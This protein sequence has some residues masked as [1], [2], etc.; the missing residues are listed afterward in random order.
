[1]HAGGLLGA[2]LENNTCKG[3]RKIG[4]SRG[5]SRSD[6]PATKGLADPVEISGAE[7]ALLRCLSLRQ[8][9]ITPKSISHWVKLR[10]MQPPLARATP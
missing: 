5:V 1:M 6:A 10:V 7:L 4:V 9:Y 8:G 2:V 3:V